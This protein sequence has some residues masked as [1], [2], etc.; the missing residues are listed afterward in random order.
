MGIMTRVGNSRWGLECRILTI[1]AHALIESMVSYGLTVTG[2]AATPKDVDN[3]DVQILNPTARR[4]AGVGMSARRE[5]L[6]TLAD[7]RTTGNHYL[8]KTANVFDRSLRAKGTQVQKH[9]LQFLKSRGQE[10]AIWNDKQRLQKLMI[11]HNEKDNAEKTK[12]YENPQDSRQVA[13]INLLETQWWT[14]TGDGDNGDR[15]Q[16]RVNTESPETTSIYSAQAPELEGQ[17]EE[18]TLTFQFAGLRCW[19]EVACKVLQ[20]IGW[21]PSCVYEDTIFPTEVESQEIQWGKMHPYDERDKDKETK[22][23]ELEIYLLEWIQMGLAMGI[24]LVYDQ[25]KR[26]IQDVHILGKMIQKTSVSGRHPAG[27]G[28][29][30]SGKPVH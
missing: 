5:V 14:A 29:G 6:Y 23:K 2:S 11:H 27:Q 28:S 7:M 24:V 25:G 22:Q 1:T 9:L 26:I 21:Q 3:M 30:E 15:N 18:K 20:R 10:H 13:Q 4:V 17:P 16:E 12:G 8:L 19:R